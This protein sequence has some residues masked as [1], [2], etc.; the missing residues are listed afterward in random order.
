MTSAVTSEWISGP[1]TTSC[2]HCGRIGKTHDMRESG[3]NVFC[4]DTDCAEQYES[5]HRRY[6]RSWSSSNEEEE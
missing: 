5:S 2:D 6:S 4:P 3:Q 1:L